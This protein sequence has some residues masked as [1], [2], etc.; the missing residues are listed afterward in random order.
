[1]TWSG[2]FFFFF[3]FFF[4][5]C[6]NLSLNVASVSDLSHV[7]IVFR[8]CQLC[9]SSNILISPIVLTFLLGQSLVDIKSIAKSY[10]DMPV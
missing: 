4:F 7:L 10:F 5:R 1:M 2:S 3:F 6:S 8:R 9:G